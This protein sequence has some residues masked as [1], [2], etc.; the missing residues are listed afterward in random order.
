MSLKEF[1]DKNHS[2]INTTGHVLS[3]L[4]N[5]KIQKNQRQ[6][7]QLEVLNNSLL[8]EQN[9]LRKKEVE[10]FEKLMDQNE[11]DK[12]EKEKKEKLKTEVLELGPATK[13]LLK[14]IEHNKDEYGDLTISFLLRH[15]ELNIKKMR[16]HKGLVN[17]INFFDYLHELDEKYSE[18]NSNYEGVIEE[19]SS[20]LAES[21]IQFQSVVLG[22][23]LLSKSKKDVLSEQSEN[24]KKYLKRLKINIANELNGGSSLTSLIT[25]LKKYNSLGDK[26]N[27]MGTLH[28]LRDYP[29][30]ISFDEAQYL[31]GLLTEIEDDTDTFINEVDTKVDELLSVFE[32][33]GE[34]TLGKVEKIIKKNTDVLSVEDLEFLL[35]NSSKEVVLIAKEKIE[36]G[37]D[38]LRIALNND[39]KI[40]DKVPI[41][42][43][44]LKSEGY[45][46]FS[47][48]STVMN[49]NFFISAEYKT[50]IV[51]GF[52][53]SN[54]KEFIPE[55]DKLHKMALG[56]G[57]ASFFLLFMLVLADPE[58]S[59]QVEL[60]MIIFLFF[61]PMTFSLIFIFQSQN[62]LK[63]GLKQLKKEV[64]SEIDD[65]DRKISTIKINMR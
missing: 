62:K 32:G 12:R 54:I 4:Q 8:N 61:I 29:L 18:I 27:G 48:P 33:N 11:K 5:N 22:A 37:L 47:L 9:E 10:R 55:V 60:T 39:K 45:K 15:S 25:H 21:L 40:I 31:H 59:N 30:P 17:D 26:I 13:S 58:L 16:E 28:D 2:T 24:T 6:L 41:S 51:E 42:N 34:D 14:K 23:E 63:K 50:S 19:F 49:R 56:F 52:L 38:K 3:Y 36:N 65:I 20:E 64:E 35:R 1:L 53:K 46:G 43:Q 44:E 57:M 7:A